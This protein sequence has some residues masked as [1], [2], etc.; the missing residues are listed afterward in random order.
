MSLRLLV[1]GPIG[2]TY[3]E[4]GRDRLG[5]LL[6]AGARDVLYVTASAPARRAAVADL[7]RRLGA[8]CGLR[9]VTLRRLP[10]EI[11]RR[12]RV[13]P[14]AVLD[15][16]VDQLLVERAMRRAS[17]AHFP[18][19]APVS[20]LA[21][22]AGKLVERLEREGATPERYADA[23]AALGIEGAG[24]RL[25]AE[26][27]PA[28]AAARAPHGATGAAL[29]ADALRLVRDGS[30]ALD[31]TLLVLEDLPPLPQVDAA[32]V[33]ALVERAGRVIAMHAHA[34]QL[35]EAPSCRALRW[36]R[37]CATWTEESVPAADAPFAAALGR[38]FSPRHASAAEPRP[39]PAVRVT[40]LD[41]VGEAGEVL[42]AAR[43]VRRELQAP[44]AT[45]HRPLRPGEV[46][47]VVHG[48]H[49]YRALVHEIFGAAGLP[50]AAT[51]ARPLS[52]TP[53]GA[54]LLRLLDA[55]LD[56]ERA[57]R[58]DA[59]ALLR[60]PHLDVAPSRADRLERRVTRRGYLGLDSWDELALAVLGERTTNRI[61]RLRRALAGA[62]ADFAKLRDAADAGAVVRD[63]ARELRLVG[64]AVFARRRLV[65][66][67]PDAGLAVRT[68]LAIRE[69]AE[70]WERIELL[71]D[72][73][74]P[75]MLRVD[76]PRGN[77]SGLAAAEAWA[78]HLRAAMTGT[79]LDVE[80]PPAD[81]VRVV[82]TGCGCDQPARITIVLGLLEKRF[83]RQLRQ[84]AFL[85]DEVR[86]LLRDDSGWALPT[87][88]E[89]TDGERE[90]FLRAVACTTDA[91]Y[92]ACPS[93]D[94][95]GKPR[96][97]SFF[98][99]DLQAALG[100]EHR[101][102]VERA[103]AAALAP[104]LDEASTTGELLATVSHDLW[105]HLARTPE[106]ELRRCAALAAH[107]TL[108]ERGADLS[109]VRDG[110]Q[111][112]RRPHVSPALL[113]G[114]PHRT[115]LLSASQLGTLGQCGYKH[116]A[117]KVLEPVPI[118]TPSYDALY[119]GS[120]LH[121]A[122]FHWATQLGGWERGLDALDEL[123]AWLAE[124]ATRW[125]PAV[126]ASP[127]SLA[128]AGRDFERLDA[129]LRAELALYEGQ[130]LV[131]PAWHELA[132]GEPPER[133]ASCDA[134]SVLLPF[135]L[136]LPAAEAE[137]RT[138][139][140]R[141]SI[142]RVDVIEVEGRRY[143]VVLDYK[144]G[145]NARYYKKSMLAGDDLQLRL[146][147]LALEHFWGVTPIG[148]LYLGFGDGV[149]RGAVHAAFADRIPGIDH[150]DVELMHDE[151]WD[152]FVYRDTAARI[153]PL[154]EKLVSVDIAPRPRRGDCGF[155]DLRP[156]C[157]FDPDARSDADGASKGTSADGSNG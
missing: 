105:Q 14:A 129:L 7:T 82:G 45:G 146:Y 120:V 97:R 149:R 131:R 49:G 114:R 138:V 89:A 154:V 23:L 67:V 151:A 60:S 44:S 118:A 112:P 40:R 21:H 37:G 47:V 76:P 30:T 17:A 108:L 157:R 141:G 11:A 50:V 117:Q 9:V 41:A 31:D 77:P 34:P 104:R 43:I 122:I 81:A 13:A 142:D 71:F 4:V 103:D 140:F 139:R 94:A 74:V 87:S 145:E 5:A 119:K 132:F 54:V 96:V 62:R 25:I 19:D 53:I 106:A 27:W 84:D 128:A 26:L 78:R 8:V 86:R 109:A 48:D 18:A 100:A 55:I 107:D 93:T 75:A 150:R 88:D 148:A 56:P 57:S 28:L 102:A 70:A 95:A 38:C 65:R 16:I 52:D 115:L 12:A 66:D 35:P 3:R 58:E 101:I 83:P 135:E 1:S 98:L 24:P 90:C 32:L 39:T 99:D 22:A 143:G 134:A 156:I 91:L 144:T 68:D 130:G 6:A 152:D 2:A 147:L 113:E 51:H 79:S 125:E 110:R 133:L 64:N 61:N 59:V 46:R 42:L 80:R 137:P 36:L 92:L 127:L 116:F 121:D 10:A 85:G 124:Q 69:D 73:T 126:R 72:Q 153:A 123:G 155:C 29:V 33:R 63:L 111:S 20:G 15:P 136:L